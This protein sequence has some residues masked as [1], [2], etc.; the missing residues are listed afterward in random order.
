MYLLI[1]LPSPGVLKYESGSYLGI[2]F[3]VASGLAL[4]W[5]S[6]L[7]QHDNSV[8]GVH[9]RPESEMS[10]FEWSDVLTT[11]SRSLK[12]LGVVFS[13]IA[14]SVE[15]EMVLT[16]YWIQYVHILVWQGSSRLPWKQVLSRTHDTKF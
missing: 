14:V 4:S 2:S 10:T 7:M 6:V 15:E 8:C 1:L 3:L 12:K 11:I 13:H 9:V 16:W 5:T